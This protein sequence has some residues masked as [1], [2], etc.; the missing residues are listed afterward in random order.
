MGEFWFFSKSIRD[1]FPK[2]SLELSQVEIP[3]T[4]LAEKGE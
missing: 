3:E 4:L 1:G 2:E